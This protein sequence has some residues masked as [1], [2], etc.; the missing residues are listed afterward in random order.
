MI[1][2]AN[3]APSPAQTPASNIFFMPFDGGMIRYNNFIK[4]MSPA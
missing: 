2:A 1:Y 3:I 4:I